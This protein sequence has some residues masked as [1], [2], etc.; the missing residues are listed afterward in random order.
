MIIDSTGYWYDCFSGQSNMPDI[1]GPSEFIWLIHHCRKLYTNS[2][3]AFIFSILFNKPCYLNNDTNID[4][5]IGAVEHILKLK[6]LDDKI[7]N[8]YEVKKKLKE[9][10]KK[11]HIYLKQNL[12]HSYTNK[13]AFV[14]FRM[15]NH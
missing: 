7:Q 13:R 8:Y 1:V 11:S 15:I 9:E 14:S 12:I 6:R 4:C 10:R 5:R 2:Y 3:H